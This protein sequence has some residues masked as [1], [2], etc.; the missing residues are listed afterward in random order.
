MLDHIKTTHPE[1]LENIEI[2]ENSD[3]DEEMEQVDLEIVRYNSEPSK[4]VQ[5]LEYW[6]P[7]HKSCPILYHVVQHL[8]CIPATSF[9]VEQLYSHTGNTLYNRRNILSPDKLDKIM[10]VFYSFLIESFIYS[11]FGIK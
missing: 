10:T 11:N 7:N 6:Q 3:Y 8:F 1:Y 9:P 5:P 2:N 4:I